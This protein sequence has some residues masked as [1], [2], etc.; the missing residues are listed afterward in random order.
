MTI[1]LRRMNALE[2]AMW[3]TP[4]VVIGAGIGGIVKKGW[5]FTS[6]LRM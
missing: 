3:I 1:D 5:A 2:W 4:V 6:S